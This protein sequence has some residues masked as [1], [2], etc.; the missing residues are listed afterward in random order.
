MLKIILKYNKVLKSLLEG[1]RSL[2]KSGCKFIVIPCNTAHYWYEDLKSKIKIPIINMPKE[3]FIHTKKICK[4]IQ[5]LD[6][7]LQKVL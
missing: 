7:L 6:F 3:V 4:K 1:C 5:K 2:E